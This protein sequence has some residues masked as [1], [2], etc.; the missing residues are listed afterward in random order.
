MSRA[1]VDANSAADVMAAAVL[2]AC[3]VVLTIELSDARVVLNEVARVDAAEL[4]QLVYTA[5]K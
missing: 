4:L 3:D 2:L 5:K 1:Y